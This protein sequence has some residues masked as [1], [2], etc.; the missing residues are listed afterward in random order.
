M[1]LTI[2]YPQLMI[3][4]IFIQTLE[5]MCVGPGVVDEKQFSGLLCSMRV[6]C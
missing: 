2:I 6:L 5:Y 3:L 1:Y 4:Q